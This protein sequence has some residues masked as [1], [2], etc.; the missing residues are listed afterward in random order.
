MASS[1]RI[2]TLRV[3]RSRLGKHFG[4]R[5]DRTSTLKPKVFG[6]EASIR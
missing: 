5:E 2:E 4:L 1:V 3:N 6:W